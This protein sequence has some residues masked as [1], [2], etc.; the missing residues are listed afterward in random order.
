M[1]VTD[2]TFGGHTLKEILGGACTRS[3]CRNG[4]P[5]GH[6]AAL[7]DRYFDYVVLNEIRR[8]GESAQEICSSI[9]GYVNIFK[10]ANPNVKVYYIVHDGVYVSNYSKTWLES[11][12][13]IEKLGYEKGDGCYV[14]PEGRKLISVGDVADKG[15]KNV[16]CLNFW[17]DQVNNGGAFWV[18]GNHCNKLYRYFLGN[19]V[20]N[21]NKGQ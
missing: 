4:S 7:K 15:W 13:L 12:E 3:K 11:L 9:E 2:W 6:L 16:D 20:V 18:H 8:D 17:I 10:D 21:K 5:E 14:H 19:R 1:N